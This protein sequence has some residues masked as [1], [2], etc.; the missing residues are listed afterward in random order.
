VDLGDDFYT[1][2]QVRL[3]KSG[4]G[5]LV[6]SG[7]PPKSSSGVLALGKTS[8]GGKLDPNGTAGCP[9]E[10]TFLLCAVRAQAGMLADHD[11]QIARGQHT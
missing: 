5:V 6:A 11:V 10:S 2:W 7:P 8:G 9:G 3:D 4:S 1:I